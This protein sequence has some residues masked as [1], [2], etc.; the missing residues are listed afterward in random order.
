MIAAVTEFA[1]VDRCFSIALAR[2]FLYAGNLLPLLLGCLYL[3]F[4][5]RHNLLVNVQIVVEILGYE[6]VH[7]ASDGGSYIEFRQ[8]LFVVS[9]LFPH[10][11]APEFGFGLAFEVRFLNQDA[12]GSN[13]A[14]PA[15]GRFVVFLEEVFEGFG[16]G[17]AVS[18]KM[19]AAVTGVLAVNERRYVLAMFVIVCKHH[20]YVF[21]YQMD[22]G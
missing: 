12:D 5:Y 20:L 17:F 3:F 15:V 6:I 22:R 11:V 19:G 10:I 1:V 16:D 9:L 2:L 18:G 4:Y 7:I 13:N 14:L 21:A 8:A